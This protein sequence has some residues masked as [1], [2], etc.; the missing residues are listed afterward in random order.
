MKGSE[1]NARAHEFFKAGEID[2]AIELYEMNVQLKHDGAIAYNR[3]ITIYSKR[4]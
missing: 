2:K 3:L 1:R 4:K